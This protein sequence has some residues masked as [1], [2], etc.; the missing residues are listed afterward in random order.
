MRYVL[1]FPL[2]LPGDLFAW[3]TVWH[4]VVH[5]RVLQGPD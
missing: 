2:T 4:D 1:H 5:A 3:E